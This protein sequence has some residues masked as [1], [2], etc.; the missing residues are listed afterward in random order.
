[1]WYLTDE[2]PTTWKFEGV[3][4]PKEADVPCADKGEKKNRNNRGPPSNPSSSDDEP[5]ER[6][7]DLDRKKR[8]DDEYSETPRSLAE[9]FGG[10]SVIAAIPT[11][12]TGRAVT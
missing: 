2:L 6:K 3:E 8:Y 7:R 4:V 5:K 11:T 1:V 12:F 10:K 9:I